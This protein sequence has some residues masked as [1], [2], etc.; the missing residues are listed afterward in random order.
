MITKKKLKRY[1]ST[2]F[3][4]LVGILFIVVIVFFYLLYKRV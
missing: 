2:F 4:V 1:F 3:P